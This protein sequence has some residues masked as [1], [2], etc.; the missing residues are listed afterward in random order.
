[1]QNN[2]LL[3]LVLP[4]FPRKIAL[5]K[6]KSAQPYTLK[7]PPKD[8]KY[9]D[10]NNYYW[11]PRG[12]LLHKKTHTP[13][14]KE[15]E[16]IA[17]RGQV[18]FSQMHFSKRSKLIIK[19]KEYVYSHVKYLKPI[20]EEHFPLRVDMDYY[21]PATKTNWDLDN[22]WIW[23]KVTLDVLVASKIIPDDSVKYITHA[24]GPRFVPVKTEEERKIIYRVYSD[25]RPELKIK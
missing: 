15:A 11:S 9:Y 17:I 5:S 6:Q 19:L 3:E 23:T 25:N 1:M 13:V 18:L 22:L 16:E 21:S 20:P 7:R 8:S 2:P 4:E 10:Q 24:P 12:I 14:Y